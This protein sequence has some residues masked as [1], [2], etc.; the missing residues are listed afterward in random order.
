MKPGKRKVLLE[1]GPG[2]SPVAFQ[3]K[4]HDRVF[5]SVAKGDVFYLKDKYGKR[6]HYVLGDVEKLPIKQGAASRI[7][8]RMVNAIYGESPETAEKMLV[9]LNKALKKGKTLTLSMEHLD[10]GDSR[11]ALGKG[12]FDLLAPKGRAGL[13]RIFEKV[14]FKLVKMQD[15]FAN[16]TTAK[17]ATEF[18]NQIHNSFNQKVFLLK[19]KKIRDV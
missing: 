17:R 5:L 9:G 19:L 16:P 1:I 13:M 12:G 2:W 3:H 18:E 15:V 11:R 7:E 8:A 4:G 6:A 14:G 10:A